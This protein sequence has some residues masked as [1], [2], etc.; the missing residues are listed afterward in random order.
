MLCT[1]GGRPT[2]K[3]PTMAQAMGAD[4]FRLD[5]ACASHQTLEVLP[6]VPVTAS[7][8]KCCEG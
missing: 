4:C 8:F 5:K 1:T 3:V 7:S 2:P 6:L